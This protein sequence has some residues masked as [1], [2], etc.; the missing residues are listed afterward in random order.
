ME[1][2]KLNSAYKNDINIIMNHLKTYIL[3]TF[4]LSIAVSLA[5]GL[6]GGHNSPIINLG[7]VSMFIPAIALAVLKFKN[8]PFPQPRKTTATG[9]WYMVALFIFPVIIHSASLPVM[10]AQHNGTLPW[11]AWLTTG[12]D[13]FYHTP[14]DKNWGALTKGGLMFHIILNAVAGVLVVSVL[15]F[16]EEIGWRAWML[17]GLI[18]RYN[19]KKGIAIGAIICALWHVPYLLAGIH[20]IPNAP[21]LPVIVLYTLG[22]MG[23]AIILGWLWVNTKSIIIVSLA[24]GSLNN[25]GQ[26]AFKYLQDATSSNETLALVAAVN[27]GLFI[28][29]VVTLIFIKNRPVVSYTPNVSYGL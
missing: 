13:G 25:W 7:Y 21:L 20:Y 28:A 27:L 11:Q 1:V 26:Y 6:T 12:S 15:A 29:G 2:E 14:A 4:T 18:D 22:Q 17:P 3:I 19:V 23:V 10:A 16:F 9:W 8:V 5:V 24:H